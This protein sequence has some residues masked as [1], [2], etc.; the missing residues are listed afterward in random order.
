MRT[1]VRSLGSVLVLYSL[2]SAP[3]KLHL[4]C[5]QLAPRAKGFGVPTHGTV[6][7][8]LL[9]AIYIFA[10]V[11][12]GKL[13][14]H[15]LISGRLTAHSTGNSLRQRSTTKICTVLFFATALALDPPLVLIRIHPHLASCICSN[16]MHP[17]ITPSRHPFL[18]Y[19]Y[20]HAHPSP[21]A[22][23]STIIQSP[24]LYACVL[25]IPSL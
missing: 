5:I 6:R 22:S 3:A 1:M 17:R 24:K 23:N 8:A 4:S 10:S 11:Q 13:T 14:P 18:S 21:Q 15:T 2:M 12:E 19:I 25:A 20:L 9:G 7:E 16:I